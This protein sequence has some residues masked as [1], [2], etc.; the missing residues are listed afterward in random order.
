[1]NVLGYIKMAAR[2]G[3]QSQQT[4]AGSVR[5]QYRLP[6]AVSY[7]TLATF[8]EQRLLLTIR[9]FLTILAATSAP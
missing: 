6:Q 8:H 4:A 2:G 7:V 1:M 5:R 9:R 3:T